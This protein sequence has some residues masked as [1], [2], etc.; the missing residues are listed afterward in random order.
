MVFWF[1]ISN[2]FKI[3]GIMIV[4]RIIDDGGNKNFF[5]YH[6]RIGTEDHRPMDNLVFF[7]FDEALRVKEEAL[8]QKPNPYARHGA[9]ASRGIESCLR[10]S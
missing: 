8:K 9:R 10:D 4:E 7:V 5:I 3:D 1:L 6:W 2:R